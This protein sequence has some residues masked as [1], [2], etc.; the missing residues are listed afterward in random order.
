M[1]IKTFIINAFTDKPFTGNPAGVCLIEKGI[2]EATMQS[3]AKELNL[4]E[5]AFL[6]EGKN[7][8]Q[9]N[10]RYFT[11]TV[12]IDFCG[13]ATLASSKL[14][15]DKLG[16]DNVEFTTFKNLKI[17]ASNQGNFIKMKFPIYKTVEYVPS[18]EL[19]KAFGIEDFIAS[20]YCNEL[21]MPIIEVSSKQ[22][23]L[24]IAPDFEK[25]MKGSK[26]IKE[27][28]VTTKSEEKEYDF[29]SR[30]FCPWIGIDEDP[31]TGASH[32][33]LAEYW[34]KKLN[35]TEMS[36]FQLSKRGGFLYLKVLDETN[37]EVR[38]NAQIILEGVLNV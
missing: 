34:E 10:I 13:H 37:L 26:T 36:A 14:V 29:Y 20:R 35:K 30:C 21:D 32:S 7:P 25:A 23:L 19:L 12:E 1:Q 6:Q 5:T 33:A 38:S 22:I 9:Y 8:E 4:S 27:L 16:K 3:I 11:P 17:T 24:D 18:E 28:V 2:D 15:L 31:V